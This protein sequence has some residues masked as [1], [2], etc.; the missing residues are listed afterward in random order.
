MIVEANTLERAVEVLMD[1]GGEAAKAR[2]AA[3]HM[4]DLT[5]VILSELIMSSQETSMAAKEAW[6]RTQPR[7][8]A[9]LEALR[10]CRQLDHEWRNKRSAANAIVEL[11]RTEQSN[12][13]AMARVG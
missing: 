7:F 8:Q 10:D 9:H 12:A 13:R 11:W 3:E 6:A 5:K 4:D 1:R 2:A